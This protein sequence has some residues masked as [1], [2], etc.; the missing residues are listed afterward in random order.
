[1]TSLF[2]A[3]IIQ[4]EPESF[5]LQQALQQLQFPQQPVFF[6]FLKI[7]QTQYPRIRASRI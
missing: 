6:F 2:Y 3:G 4:L 7:C 1:M 5:L